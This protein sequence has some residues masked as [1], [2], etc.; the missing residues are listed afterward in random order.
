MGDTGVSEGEATWPGGDKSECTGPDVLVCK[1]LSKD[2][3]E[4]SSL[5]GPTGREWH[6]RDIKGRG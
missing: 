2:S 3:K 5:E 4:P 1:G 6:A